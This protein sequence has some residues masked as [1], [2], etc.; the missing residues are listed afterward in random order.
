MENKTYREDDKSD[1]MKNK[2]LTFIIDDEIYGIDIEHVIEIISVP[3][4]TWIPENES[5]IK[6]VV[7]LR[8]S[9]IPVIDSRIRFNKEEREYDEFTCI[10][11]IENEDSQI[12]L[13]VDTV[14]E[15]LD[16]PERFV[17][18][19][20]NAKLKYENQFIK[21]IG[22]MNDNVQLLLDINK[23]LYP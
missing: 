6:G 19:P 13:I 5:A 23:F 1:N 11:V 4:I 17:S 14:D 15:V 9:I 20:P 2:Y 16:M 22:K 21:A 3:A 18:P 7:N 10:I 12:G 8:G